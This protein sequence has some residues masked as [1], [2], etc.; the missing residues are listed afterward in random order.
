MNYEFNA[1]GMYDM[2]A[3]PTPKK[4][5]VQQK[6]IPFCRLRSRFLIFTAVCLIRVH[7]SGQSISLTKPKM[8]LQTN[9]CNSIYQGLSSHKLFQ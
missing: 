7:N 6:Q 2:N 5:K 3:A 8:L 9:L 1:S 4:P